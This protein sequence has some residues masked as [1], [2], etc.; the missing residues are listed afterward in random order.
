MPHRPRADLGHRSHLLYACSYQTIAFRADSPVSSSTQA[1]PASSSTQV[2]RV[3]CPDI[4]RDIVNSAPSQPIAAQS[5]GRRKICGCMRV[6]ESAGT[7]LPALLLSFA[8]APTRAFQRRTASRALHRHGGLVTIPTD[9]ARKV[10]IRV[11]IGR[12]RRRHAC[13][14]L[15]RRPSTT[16]A[17]LCCVLVH[18]PPRSPTR[19]TINPARDFWCVTYKSDRCRARFMWGIPDGW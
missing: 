1:F 10:D 15:C 4:H 8:A 18:V 3:A 16:L 14:N 6:R 19:Q 7:H 2:V 17:N 13:T 9:P 11:A 12:R 5:C